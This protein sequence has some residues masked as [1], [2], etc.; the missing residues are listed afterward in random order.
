MLFASFLYP[1]F[2]LSLIS[3]QYWFFSSFIFNIIFCAAFMTG[4]YTYFIND[5]KTN[6]IIFKCLLHFYFWIFC[7]NNFTWAQCNLSRKF[8]QQFFHWKCLNTYHTH[9]LTLFSWGLL[10]L[11]ST[12]V[13]FNHLC[14]IFL[15][16]L[17]G[18]HVALFI[19]SFNG[20]FFVHFNCVEDFFSSCC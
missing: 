10:H 4:W 15:S 17:C 8:F 9:H 12:E 11:C 13:H 14:H 5:S 19:L 6:K 2:G 16:Y 3:K 1:Y 18:K 7:N 20:L